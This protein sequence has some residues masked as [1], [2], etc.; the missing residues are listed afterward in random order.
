MAEQI[1]E[2]SDDPIAEHAQKIVDT[3]TALGDAVEKERKITALLEDE[4]VVRTIDLSGI[5]RTVVESVRSQHPETAIE[6][7]VPDEVEVHAAEAVGTAIEELLTNALE[8]NDAE[9]PRAL[10]SLEE[11]AEGV[12]VTVA[13]NGPGIPEME[14]NVLQGHEEPTPL[15]HGRG[16]GLWFVQ[17]VVRR[18]GGTVVFEE[19]EPAGSIVT[20]RLNKPNDGTTEPRTVF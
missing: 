4:P 13:D 5:V 8:H 1:R 20:L 7:A 6:T 17:L 14:V 18:S 10:V 3:G 19:N 2:E 12:D 11:T 15:Y 16:L 9:S